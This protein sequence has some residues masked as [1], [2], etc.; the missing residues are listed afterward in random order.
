MKTEQL[1]KNMYVFYQ[2]GNTLIKMFQWLKESYQDNASDIMSGF[3]KKYSKD[4]A[5]R[6]EFNKSCFI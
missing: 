2:Q 3:M 1:Y 6:E 4:T 5:M